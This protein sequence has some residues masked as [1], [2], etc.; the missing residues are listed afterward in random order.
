MKSVL[1]VTPCS[2][3]ALPSQGFFIAEQLRMAGVKVQVLANAES[4]LGR[5]LDV[6]FRGMWL[7]PRYDR[8][9]VNV[10]GA[11]AFA[12]ESFAILYARLWKKHVAVLI[13]SGELAE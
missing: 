2:R 12:Y 5:L 7:I 11:R 13:H 3:D 4:G 6:I 10:Y 8:V 9:F 1:V